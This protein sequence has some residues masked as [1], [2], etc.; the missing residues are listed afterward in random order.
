MR[1]AWLASQVDPIK[2]AGLGDDFEGEA[3]RI[4]GRTKLTKLTTGS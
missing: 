2:L 1:M 3:T 4:A